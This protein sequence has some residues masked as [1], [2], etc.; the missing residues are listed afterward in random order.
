[1]SY[2]DSIDQSIALLLWGKDEDGEDD[3]ALFCG[4]FRKHNSTFYIDRGTN[5]EKIE[6]REEWLER[7]QK[8]P[9]DLRETL[10]GASYQ[11]SL[12]IGNLEE[13]EDVSSYL[14]TGMKW[15]DDA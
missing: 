12:S 1:M 13:G 3:V 11:L 15:P 6:V 8:V 5:N 4:T 2:Q 7:I 14:D 10:E 9:D